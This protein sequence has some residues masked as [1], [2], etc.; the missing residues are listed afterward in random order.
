VTR[1]DLTYRILL[2]YPATDSDSLDSG[3]K[4]KNKRRRRRRRRRRITKR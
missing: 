3:E 2:L 1:G 4:K